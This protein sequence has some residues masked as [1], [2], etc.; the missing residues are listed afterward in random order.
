M[1]LL[2]EGDSPTAAFGAHTERCTNWGTE[3]VHMPHKLQMNPNGPIQ[4]L[5]EAMPSHKG[6][7]PPMNESGGGANHSWLLSAWKKELLLGEDY[8]LCSS[9]LTI[10]QARS[11]PTINMLAASWRSSQ[12]WARAIRGKTQLWGWGDGPPLLPT[13]TPGGTEPRSARTVPSL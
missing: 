11:H 6:G 7:C 5:N 8:S 10:L 12:A 1:Q 2:A 13:A 9:Y 3:R 4:A